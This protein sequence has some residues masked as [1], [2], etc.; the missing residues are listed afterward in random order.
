MPRSDR[1]KTLPGLL[2]VAAP[3]MVMSEVDVWFD[4]SG[5][6]GPDLLN[7][8][9]PLFILASTSVSATTARDVLTDAGFTEAVEAKSAT[10]L[11]SGRGRRMTL[12]VLHDPR[13]KDGVALG[14]VDKVFHSTAKL[15]STVIDWQ[16]EQVTGLSLELQGQSAKRLAVSLHERLT[17]GTRGLLPEGRAFLNDF[18]EAVRRQ[19]APSIDRFRA[20]AMELADSTLPVALR[21]ALH[22]AARGA[23]RVR[24]WDI[25][26]LDPGLSLLFRLAELWEDRVG[27]CR[28]VHDRRDAVHRWTSR[29]E[30]MQ[31]RERIRIDLGE[32][33]EYLDYVAGRALRIETSHEHPGIQVA[34][35]LAGCARVL[36]NEMRGDSA[37]TSFAK[38]LLNSPMGQWD[39]VAIAAPG[40][41]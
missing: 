29:I 5:N 8:Q 24:D 33:N 12:A 34:D 36:F 6:T 32:G 16:I 9:Q 38:E 10:A 18:I 2:V 20:R 41:F 13:L 14:V 35:L 21:D 7:R 26:D 40:R 17:G 11:R 31:A 25:D 22:V 30:E 37:S 27:D 1:G 3:G 23:D 28:L 15:V 19:D 39:Y 4:E